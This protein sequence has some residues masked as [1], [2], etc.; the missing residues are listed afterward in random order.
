M[1]NIDKLRYEWENSILN[2]L[3]PLKTVKKYEYVRF[4]DNGI[5]MLEY[6]YK[7][8]VLWNLGLYSPSPSSYGLSR[9]DIKNIMKK[10]KFI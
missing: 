10:H 7:Y 5:L 9:N 1:L 8:N 6:S 2:R 4:Y 3:K